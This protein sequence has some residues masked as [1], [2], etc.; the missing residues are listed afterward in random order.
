[1]C[2]LCPCESLEQKSP[3]KAYLLLFLI[4]IYAILTPLDLSR[5][6]DHFGV[7]EHQNRMKNSDRV[8]AN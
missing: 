2:P 5:R 6:A 8:M 7:V 4:S 3:K 1:M